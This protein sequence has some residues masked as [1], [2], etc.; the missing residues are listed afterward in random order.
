MRYE[1]MGPLRVVDE[2]GRSSLRA[3]KI[4]V[5]LTVLLVRADQ[6]V[7][8]EQLMREIWGEAPPRRA[9]AGLHVYVSH[10][11]KFLH[12]AR[13]VESP[14]TT[15]PPGYALRLGTDEL[16]YRRFERLMNQGRVFARER[17]HEA[18][19][20]RFEEALGLWRGPLLDDVCQGPILEGFQTWLKEARLECAE[21]LVDTRLALG[22]H[23]EIVSDLY[24]LTTEHPLREAFH[25]QLMLALYR[26]GR[27][28]DALTVYQSARRTLN[29][30]LGLEPCRA[31]QNLHQAILT[32]DD[33]I[34][35][36]AA[37]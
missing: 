10:I 6:I 24:L 29:E 1:I 30:E 14:V 19:V 8:V 11:R 16:D 32:S 31:L 4:E 12:R 26:C 17:R 34:E 20:S 13:H 2:T 18:A 9:T 36:P 23:R 21:M 35:L 15:R 25:R 22:R 37:V 5:L 28:A 3:R 33:R 7:P 27:R